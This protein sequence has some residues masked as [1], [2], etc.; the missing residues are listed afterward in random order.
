M[1]NMLEQAIVDAAA[2]R[3]AARHPVRQGGGAAGLVDRTQLRELSRS[4]AAVLG[5]GDVG[6]GSERRTLA[7]PHWFGI[8]RRPTGSDRA[9]TNKGPNKTLQR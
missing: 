6:R 2:L 1:S 9:A 7:V 8:C 4:P 3:E 5:S